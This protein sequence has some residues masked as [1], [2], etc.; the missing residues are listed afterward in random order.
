MFDQLRLKVAIRQS[1]TL[2]ILLVI[3]LTL[4]FVYN[5]TAISTNID[6]N[7]NNMRNSNYNYFFGGN[8]NKDK[9]NEKNRDTLA[10][11]VDGNDKILPSDSNF[12]DSETVQTLV[13]VA[14]KDRAQNGRVKIGDNF[15]AYSVKPFILGDIVYVYDYTK[16]YHNLRNMT[17]ITIIAGAIGIVAIAL[18]SFK[19]AQK[20]VAPIENTFNKQQD[21]VANASHELKTPIT[22]INTDL[23]ILNATR[24]TM[25]EEQCKWLDSIGNQLNRMNV[26][27]TEM[28]E[29]ARIEGNKDQPQKEKVNLSTLV[30][31]VVLESEALAFERD[32]I[33]ESDVKPNVT[34]TAVNAHI[35][36]LIYILIENA[37]KYT[38]QG[39][40]VRVSVMG[41]RRKAILKVR[42]TGEGIPRDK[43][44][45][46]F[47][48][49]Y[50]TDEAHSSSNSFGLGLAIAKSIVDANGGTI[51]VDSKEGEYTEFVVVFRQ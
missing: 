33:M 50:R 40:T 12:Y 41:E 6:N 49:F 29:L 32:L 34:I 48:R 21:L 46:L 44:P 20:N 9:P 27:V 47:D 5:A 23:A 22:I 38:E 28:L 24:D 37:L 36:K 1:L 43:I 2:G 17:V 39:G 14:M 7:L 19:S 13:D 10:I 30:E 26:L 11:L 42:N 4:I 45:K 25:T 51:G 15:I 31:S 3:V 16:D 8:S 18:F 35:E